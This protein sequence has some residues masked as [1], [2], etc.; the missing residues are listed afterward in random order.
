VI[1]ASD[2]PSVPT[3]LEFLKDHVTEVRESGLP[4]LV[5]STPDCW[6][7]LLSHGYLDRHANPDDF[8]VEELDARQYR[9][10]RDLVFAYFEA[11]FDFFVPIALKPEDYTRAIREFAD[12]HDRR[13]E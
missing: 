5:F 9:V 13:K 4:P 3:W 6:V 2:R 11:G 12:L 7:D 8:T 1:A 10:F